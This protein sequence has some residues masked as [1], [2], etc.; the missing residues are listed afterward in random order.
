MDIQMLIGQAIKILVV[1]QL[2]IVS[3]L[4]AESLHGQ[5]RNKPL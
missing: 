3:L 4:P 1:L 5:V 2:A